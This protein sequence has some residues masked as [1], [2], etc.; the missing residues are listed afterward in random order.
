LSSRGGAFGAAEWY[1]AQGALLGVWALL[2]F[3]CNLLTTLLLLEVASL[4]MLLVIAH[5]PVE[6]AGHASA[7]SGQLSLLRAL[8]FFVWL[9]ALAALLMF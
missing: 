3:S 1:H 6:G 4:L 7:V 9:T 5:S 8:L 2:G